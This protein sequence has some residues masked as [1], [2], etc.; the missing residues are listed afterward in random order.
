MAPPGRTADQCVNGLRIES[1]SREDKSFKGS[2]SFADAVR[3]GSIQGK[4]LPMVRVN[5]IGNGW[6][7]RSAVATF[8][9]N[10]VTDCTLES[11]MQ[12]AD[13]DIL[14]RR[15]GNKQVLLTFPSKE[16]M[17]HYMDNQ[18]SMGN[19]WFSS[20][21]PWNVNLV[22][23][24][25][26]EVWLSCYGIPVHA[27]NAS[28]FLAIGQ[29]WG[30]VMQIKDDTLNSV[31]FDS[32]SRNEDRNDSDVGSIG[33]FGHHSM[34]LAPVQRSG[35]D[36]DVDV[37]F[38]GINAEVE[39]NGLA[40]N[41][42]SEHIES[43]EDRP[44]DGN[45]EHRDDERMKGAETLPSTNSQINEVSNFVRRMMM[46]GCGSLGD[47]TQS[48]G[49]LDPIRPNLGSYLGGP[50]GPAPLE[51]RATLEDVFVDSLNPHD[52]KDNLHRSCSIGPELANDKEA[53]TVESDGNVDKAGEDSE[54]ANLIK[55][56]GVLPNLNL[57]NS[58][59]ESTRPC[60]T[61][62]QI[63]P[64]EIL[65]RKAAK[66]VHNTKNKVT[67]RATVDNLVRGVNGSSS[68]AGFSHEMEL[69]EAEKCWKI[70]KYLGLVAS[71]GDEEIL[72]NIAP[73]GTV[74]LDL[75]VPILRGGDDKLRWTSD[76]SGC[77][78]IKSL[79]DWSSSYV[80]GIE[81][82][83]PKNTVG[84]TK[85]GVA[86]WGFV[87]V[88]LNRS[89]QSVPLEVFSQVDSGCQGMLLIMQ[90]SDWLAEECLDLIVFIV[91]GGP[92]EVS[93][94]AAFCIP[95]ADVA[96]SF[97]D[98]NAMSL[99]YDTYCGSGRSFCVSSDYLYFIS[100]TGVAA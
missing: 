9:D 56:K 16:R 46:D 89:I 11:F 68:S 78:S 69:G 100:T 13:K 30:E 26:R 40:P 57:S 21:S 86:E 45:L 32:V 33:D 51:D 29:R 92:N 12:Q 63:A 22:S 53:E 90:L 94:D 50:Y 23:G 71:V 88:G 74:W 60:S 83:R 91:F 31:R 82:A 93:G 4:D 25:G 77:F 35:R 59:V 17:D 7:Y 44:Q 36:D 49:D 34:E 20:I 55:T 27:W 42:N 41:I 85:I 28:T 99:S 70:R 84:L 47:G 43:G 62:N 67:T 80:S 73:L 98:F 96:W 52:G 18:Q 76:P 65:G 19:Q 48:L 95:P 72:L 81:H 3:G 79:Y 61:A 75:L 15:L 6:L 39:G 58:E 2:R 66:R 37:R 54:S 14:F 87:G 8:G 38:I 10:C 64:G 5:S 24:F 1:I 97:L